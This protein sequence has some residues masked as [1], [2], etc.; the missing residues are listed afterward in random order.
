MLLL[1]VNLVTIYLFPLFQA[2]L[3]VFD[4]DIEENTENLRE[5]TELF[6]MNDISY[7]KTGQNSIN[8]N[9]WKTARRVFRHRKPS[10]VVVLN[11]ALTLLEK[12][13]NARIVRIRLVFIRI[14]KENFL[15]FM[16]SISIDIKIGEIDTL[17]EKYQ[18]DIY[19]E[20]R[21]TEKR[22]NI[23]TSNLTS[24]QQTQLLHDNMTVRLNELNS[25]VQWSPQLFIENAIGQ[26]GE[27]DRWFTIKKALAKSDQP[28]L[29]TP[30]VNFSICEHR[31]IKGVFWEKLELNHVNIDLNKIFSL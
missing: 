3:A 25:I 13:I 17:N 5:T 1:F 26:I 24:Q 31:R 28:S 22:I 7:S 16:K 9:N 11:P 30:F 27:Q 29:S 19:F 8:H 4:E 18:A 12:H 2:P 15:F 6:D 20:A 23:N 21:W 10:S 14:G